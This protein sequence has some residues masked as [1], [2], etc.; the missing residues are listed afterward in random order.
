MAPASAQTH[1]HNPASYGA[2]PE[3][4]SLRSRPK[5]PNQDPRAA[6]GPCLLRVPALQE[7]SPR[8][9]VCEA[10][11][12]NKAPPVLRP[13]R[14]RFA[15]FRPREQT[16]QERRPLLLSLPG[17][18]AGLSLL[19]PY[20]LLLWK[21]SSFIT[22]RLKSYLS[23]LLSL[24]AKSQTFNVVS[25][26]KEESSFQTAQTPHANTVSYNTSSGD[27]SL[28]AGLVCALLS[29]AYSTHGGDQS[30]CGVGLDGGRGFS[31]IG[32]NKISP[33]CMSDG[34]F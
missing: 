7:R 21:R 17:N 15:S 24:M 22:L 32:G 9:P 12:R 2:Y 30:H 34:L 20:L 29:I 26:F 19:H 25:S 18:S 14:P 3:C 13:Q 27:S 28:I 1:A 11:R 6:S 23:V 16:L 33:E 8:S 5:V 4:V 31:W 10:R